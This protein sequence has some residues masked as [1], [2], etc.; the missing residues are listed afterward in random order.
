M[1]LTVY[2][3][4]T[5]DANAAI[6]LYQKA[7]DAK[8]VSLMHYGDMPVSDNSTP[9]PDAKRH[10][11]MHALLDLGESQL[12]L[13]DSV[14]HDVVKGNNVSIAVSLDSPQKVKDA[15]MLLN[16]DATVVMDLQETFFSPLFGELIDK[17]GVNWKLISD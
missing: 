17:F 5:G 3:A 2:L 11:I 8:V 9:M 16:Q 4:F 6:E 15:F 7:F 1:K 10:Y 13:S 12:R 14:L